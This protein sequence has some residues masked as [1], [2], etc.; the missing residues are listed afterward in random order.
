MNK[1]K[2]AGIDIGSNAARLIIKDLL[3]AEN[4]KMIL[5]SRV[6]IRLPVRLGIDVF[7]RGEIGK[8]NQKR[9]VKAIHKNSEIHR[10]DAYPATQVHHIFLS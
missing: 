6:Y 1:K 8:E 2:F 5:K 4:G 3:P 9:F 10:F 7:L